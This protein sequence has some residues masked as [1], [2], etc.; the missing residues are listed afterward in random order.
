[1]RD[2]FHLPAVNADQMERIEATL[3]ALE[4]ERAQRLKAD[5]EHTAPTAPTHREPPPPWLAGVP[6]QRRRARGPRWLRRDR[7]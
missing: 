3:R 7:E 1:V 4:L 5:A 2:A 6:L